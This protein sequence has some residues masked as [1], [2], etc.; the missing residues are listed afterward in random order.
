MAEKLPVF[1]ISHGGG[2]WPWIDEM[3]VMFAGSARW[4]SQLPQ[5]LP[6]E[7]KAVLSVTGH[8]EATEFT[9]GTSPQPPMMYDYFGFPEHTYHI[10]YAAPG[11]P[12]VAARVQELLSAERIRCDTDAERGFDH[13][14]FVPLYLM[15]PE[16]KV[17]VVQ[18]SIK[19][20]MDPEE[21]LQLGAALQPLR[22]EGVLIIGSGL[23]YHNMSGFRGGSG[24]PTSRTFEQWLTSAVT[25][26]DVG[27]RATRLVHWA[28]APMARSAHPREDHLIPL[29]VAA[30]AAGIDT[31]RRDF[32]DDAMGIAMASYRFGG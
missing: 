15:Y 7:P 26:P 24:G 28:E 9:V 16:A 4:L 30:G 27:T 31:G 3:R 5:T 11:S 13:G 17:P 19:K 21:H 25:E 29:M 23:S 8:W 22:D 12:A 1:F 20:S 14:T 2:P 32:L 6:A 18:L 10:K